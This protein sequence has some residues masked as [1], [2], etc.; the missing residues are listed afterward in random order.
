MTLKTDTD[1]RHLARA[2]ELAEKGWAPSRPTR[3]V[4]AVIVRDGGV[5]G[6]GFHRSRRRAPRRGRGDPRARRRNSAAR[7]STSRSS[8]A[9]TRAAHRRV[10]MRSATPE[11]PASSS[12]PMTR[13]ARIRPR[14]RD[15]AR[16]G[17]RRR[18]GRRRAGG[19][20]APAQPAVPQA[21]AHRTPMGDV[22]VGDVA[23]RQGRD[24]QRR[25][26]VDLR[27]GEPRAGTPLAGRQCD[28]VAVGIG[29]ALAD[30]PL[31]T[32]RGGSTGRRAP[33]TPGHLR[34]ARPPTAELAA[35]PRRPHNSAHRGRVARRA[36]D[37]HRRARGARRRRDRRHR[38]ERAS[39][40]A[41][42]TRPARRRGRDLDPAR[43]RSHSWPACFST[44]ARSTRSA[45]SS[46]RCCSAAGPPATRWRARASSDRRRGP[47][48]DARLRAR[49]RRS[50][51]LGSHREW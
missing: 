22:Q 17:H 14:P 32:A 30:D 2:I 8:P 34:L 46:R 12:P 31:L 5:L 48:A 21:R 28:A 23:R 43:G 41:L 4:G 6:E 29:T 37:G 50:A 49:R 16:R 18:R 40:R 51:D 45:C 3:V 42:G 33:A 36:A 27:R 10:R 19:P 26:E 15:P 25:L 44:P 7:R 47:G 39:A 13:R 38:R 1:R 35:G 24:A 20:R 9:A 11:S